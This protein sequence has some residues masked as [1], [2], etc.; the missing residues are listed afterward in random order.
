MAS[1]VMVPRPRRSM[2]GPVILII[3]GVVFLL[4][5]MGFLRWAGLGHMFARYWPLLLILGGA[6]KIWEHQQAQ[7]EGTRAPGIGVGGVFLVI[8]IVVCGLIA[9]QATHVDWGSLRDNIN[10]D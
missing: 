4:G 1:P 6:I 3:L 7:R 5:T 8:V 9:T 10:I 2:S